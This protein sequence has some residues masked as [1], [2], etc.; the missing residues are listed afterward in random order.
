MGNKERLTKEED[1]H[2]EEIKTVTEM[3]AKNTE[4]TVKT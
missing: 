4:E 3:C 1:R 2:K